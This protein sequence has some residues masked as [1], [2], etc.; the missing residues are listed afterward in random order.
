MDDGSANP[1]FVSVETQNQAQEPDG[2]KPNRKIRKHQR[3]MMFQDF[4]I[5]SVD[6]QKEK[7][8]TDMSHDGVQPGRADALQK[9]PTQNPSQQRGGLHGRDPE[10]HS[11]ATQAGS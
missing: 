3:F 4:P 5:N 10:H 7:S 6:C 8:A 1:W 2:A 11:P 9:E